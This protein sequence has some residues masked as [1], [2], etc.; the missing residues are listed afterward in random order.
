[1][2]EYTDH[3]A[4]KAIM[5]KL[6]E[7]SDRYRINF[8]EID[9]NSFY[10]DHERYEINISYSFPEKASIYIINSQFTKAIH[11]FPF[12]YEGVGVY[13]TYYIKDS[14]IEDVVNKFIEQFIPTSSSYIGREAYT[15]S[16]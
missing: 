10:I 2:V 12:N 7:K 3:D 15:Y 9:D 14:I 16:T 8:D 11:S 1:M 4:I 13:K 5:H 6:E